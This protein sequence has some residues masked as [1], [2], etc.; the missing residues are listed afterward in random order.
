MRFFALILI[1]FG[2]TTASLA[3]DLGPTEGS[4]IPHRLET[5][6]QSGAAQSFDSVKGANGAVIVF[7]RSADW[8]PYCQRQLIALNKI[9]GGVESAGY[10]LVGVSYDSVEKLQKFVKK[11]SI[12]FTLLSDPGSQIIDAY[13][14]R[15][16]TYPEGHYAHG[17]PHPTVLVVNADG[18]IEKK[19]FSDDYKKRPETEVILSAIGR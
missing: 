3:D 12:E 14:I 13:G 19:F 6:D 5:V 15:N 10:K 4:T 16:T 17:V 18:I 9:N 7:F 8:C 11:R 2:L 1:G